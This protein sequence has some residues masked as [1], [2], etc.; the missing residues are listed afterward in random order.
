MVCDYWLVSLVVHSLST[1]LCILNALASAITI[2]KPHADT[3]ITSNEF[4]IEGLVQIIPFAVLPVLQI[5][6]GLMT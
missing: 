5:L 2:I 6:E 1:R 4:N 3:N